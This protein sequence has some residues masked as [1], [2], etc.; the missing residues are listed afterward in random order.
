MVA[1][2]NCDPAW[3][4]QNVVAVLT[5]P[6]RLAAMAAAARRAGA[7]DAAAVLARAVLEVARDHHA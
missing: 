6:P 4:A 2:E 7:R 5:D 1:D 3:V